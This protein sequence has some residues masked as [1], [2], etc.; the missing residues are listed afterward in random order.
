MKKETKI[1][2]CIVG[3]IVS[4]I[5]IFMIGCAISYSYNTDARNA[6]EASKR[7]YEAQQAYEQ[8]KSN[9]N[10]T[11]KDIESYQRSVNILKNAK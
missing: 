2:V 5:A 1:I 7:A 10:K 9:Y 8:A 3:I 6:K 4:I 11:K